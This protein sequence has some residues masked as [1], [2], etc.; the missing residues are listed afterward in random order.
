MVFQVEEVFHCGGH[1]AQHTQA[2]LVVAASGRQ[3]S[4]FYVVVDD[5][6]HTGVKDLKLRLDAPLHVHIAQLLE[7]LR[8]IHEH[9]GGHPVEGP[10]VIGAHLDAVHGAHVEH[11][12]RIAC[13]ISA[14]DAVVAG[15]GAVDDHI[16]VLMGPDE[17]NGFLEAR[18]VHGPQ[19]LF[20][21]H[22]K[23]DDGGARLPAGIGILGDLLRGLGNVI[24]GR[25]DRA[26][27]GRGDNCFC[28][29]QVDSSHLGLV[30]GNGTPK[31]APF[32]VR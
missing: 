29:L 27:E 15:G 4:L 20:V 9:A 18:G 2:E 23:V 6:Q 28:S 30:A 25:G 12:D 19:A 32:P 17:F 10:G 22:M 5:V 1:S 13:G 16:A 24:A 31:R 11:P 3:V 8:G 21:P 7:E 26:G 14:R